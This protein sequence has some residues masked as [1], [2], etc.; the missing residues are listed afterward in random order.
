MKSKEEWLAAACNL[1]PVIDWLEMFNKDALDWIGRIQQDAYQQGILDALKEAAELVYTYID[2]T[3][4]KCERCAQNRFLYE[5]LAK[6]R[7]AKIKEFEK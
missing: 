6:L 1:P 2:C 3:K 5:L 7:T 4:D